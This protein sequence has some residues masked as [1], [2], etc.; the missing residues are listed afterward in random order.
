MTKPNNTRSR[1]MSSKLNVIEAIKG[2]LTTRVVMS[3][4]VLMLSQSF[5]K[6][7]D[8]DIELTEATK[9]WKMTPRYSPSLS[10]KSGSILQLTEISRV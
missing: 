3:L 9:Y 8:V 7:Q 2:T 5:V 10:D 1:L 4:F 6:G